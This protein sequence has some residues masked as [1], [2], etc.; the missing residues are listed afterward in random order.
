[1]AA[2]CAI[3]VALCGYAVADASDVVPGLITFQ[4]PADAAKPYPSVPGEATVERVVAESSVATAPLPDRQAVQR[5]LE[6]VATAVKGKGVVAA[7]VLDA[8][9]GTEL[10]AVQPNLSLIPASNMK[11]ITAFAA[12]TTL[13]PEKTFATR[14]V[15]DGASLYLVGGGDIALAPD[16]GTPT[17][18]VGRA[19]LG[20]LARAAAQK[21]TDVNSVQVFVDTSSYSGPAYEPSLPADSRIWVTPSS[22]VAMH[23][24]KTSDSAPDGVASSYPADPAAEALTAFVQ[25]LNAAGVK[26]VA[27]GHQKAPVSARPLAEVNSA[28]VR[29]LVDHMLLVSENSLAEALAHQV[30]LAQGKPG[31]FVGGATAVVG[32]LEKA[33]VPLADSV[34]RDGS[35]LSTLNRI[36]PAVFTRLLQNVWA[37]AARA[38]V[39]GSAGAPAQPRRQE[40]TGESAHAGA[41]EHAGE[42]KKSG[43][44]VAG[45]AQG[46]AMAAIGI[47]VPIG[48]VDGSLHTRFVNNAGTGVV[49]A[50]T[51]TLDEASSLSGFVL[52]RNGRPLTFS[53]VVNSAAGVDAYAYRPAID[54]A[55]TALAQL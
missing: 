47:G 1:M 33:G 48:G 45:A 50:K 46:C 23:L 14:A 30:A 40:A 11:L 25:Q 18:T 38:E 53:I 21:L 34:I 20:D 49:H 19:G 7:R 41:P 17:A 35:G 43:G 37:C 44:S 15:R 9:T 26:A 12:L 6:T 5:A 16:R 10:G 54:S 42:P 31:S 3:V 22:P 29:S 55:V 27:A 8:L 13:G 52:T 28:P 39:S 2:V 51:G 36:S 4:A 24:G 32:V